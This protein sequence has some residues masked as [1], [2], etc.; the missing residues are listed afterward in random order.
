MNTVSSI[1]TIHRSA[2]DAKLTGL[3]GGLARHWRVDPVLTRLAAVLLALSGGIGLVLYL[4][5][6][7]LIPVDGKEEAPLWDVLGEPARRW[8][9]EVWVVITAVCCIL[10]FAALEPITP[11]GLGPAL[12]LALLWYFGYHRH[13]SPSSSAAADAL[14]GV[15][16]GPTEWTSGSR[17]TGVQAAAPVEFYQYAGPSTPFT[18]AAA[19]WRQRVEEAQ[20]SAT[21]TGSHGASSTS[22]APEYG[23]AAHGART[24]DAAA[25]PSRIDPGRAPAERPRTTAG[26][27]GPGP[28]EDLREPVGPAASL[29]PAR[30]FG[31]ESVNYDAFLALPDPAGLYGQPSSAAGSSP[32]VPV[33]RSASVSARRLRLVA[34][35]AVGLTL[36][37][38]GLADYLGTRVPPATYFASCLLVLGLTLVAATWCGRARGILPVALLVLLGT[39]AATL[40]GPV[41]HSQGWS[42]E[43]VR[44]TTAAQLVP[45]DR[46]QLGRLQVDLT[47]LTTTANT[48][49]TAH[50]GTGALEVS[51]PEN[52]NVVINWRVDTGVMLVNGEEVQAGSAHSGQVA[53]PAPDP[54]KKTLTLD[55]SVDH[56]LVEVTR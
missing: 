4:A 32:A 49:Y 39:L 5:G 16:S 31:S 20:R 19:A 26:S 53:P 2:T 48:T 17:W 43:Q 30:P 11:L 23:A 7:L 50:V 22:A 14:P 40:A 52:V 27:L 10:A 38:L 56:G 33:R 6:W 36:S 45:G 8:P 12:V 21:S 9:R 46:H 47:G 51:A 37:G 42:D 1:W 13:R 54:A 18:E 24:F 35:V 15:G 44:H 3:C 28:D 55:L 25:H 29:P 41:A 34:L